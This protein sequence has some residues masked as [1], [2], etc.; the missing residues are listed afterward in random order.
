MGKGLVF[1]LENN[2][3]VYYLYMIRLGRSLSMRD[4]YVVDMVQIAAQLPP[5]EFL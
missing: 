5:T 4:G 1:M 2:Y 3:R